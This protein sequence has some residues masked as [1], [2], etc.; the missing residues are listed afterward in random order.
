LFRIIRS[1]RVIGGRPVRIMSLATGRV[2]SAPSSWLEVIASSMSELI[3][4]WSR[5]AELATFSAIPIC[6]LRCRLTSS[7]ACSA[8]SVS[9]YVNGR[10][11]GSVSGIRR[12]SP[13]RP[14]LV[15]SHHSSWVR[16]SGGLR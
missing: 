8:S 14:S 16:P 3:R 11:A 9:A 13:R 7:I 5:L 6:P 10:P 12:C 4:Y 1:S 2:V 15:M